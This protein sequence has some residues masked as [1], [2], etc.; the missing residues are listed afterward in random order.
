MRVLANQQAG[1]PPHTGIDRDELRALVAVARSSYTA[2]QSKSKAD[3]VSLPAGKSPSAGAKPAIDL[4]ALF[5]SKK[6]G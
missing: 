3:G 6:S 2:N 5:T 4:A 1:L